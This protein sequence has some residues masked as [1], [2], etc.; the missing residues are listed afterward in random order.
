[1]LRT[2]PKILAITGAALAL[3][4]LV[5]PRLPLFSS[6]LG[7]GRLSIVGAHALC[8]SAL[9]RFAEAVSGAASSRCTAVG[10]VSGLGW[11]ALLA[12]LALLA[13]AAFRTLAPA[14]ANR[15]APPA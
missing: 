11:V 4:A 1:M 5:A 12:G 7:T 14:G 9:G 6:G 2:S 13:V 8:I 10:F 15:P 3:L